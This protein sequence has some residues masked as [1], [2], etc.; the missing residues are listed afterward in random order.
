[1]ESCPWHSS[2]DNAASIEMLTHCVHTMDLGEQ[3]RSVKKAQGKDETA[4][5]K[6]TN[7]KNNNMRTTKK[8]EGGLPRKEVTFNSLAEKAAMDHFRTNY[9]DEFAYSLGAGTLA[10]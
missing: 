5:Q 2:S 9:A 10:N 8:E 3:C 1:M 4:R 6:R 7:Q